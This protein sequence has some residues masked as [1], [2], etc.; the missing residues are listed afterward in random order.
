VL[1][2]LIFSS[3]YATSGEFSAVYVEEHDS[4]DSFFFCGETDT[5][6]KD[7]RTTHGQANRDNATDERMV[8]KT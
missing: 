6:T 1:R 5:I 8:K 3:Q 2:T 7:T 4:E